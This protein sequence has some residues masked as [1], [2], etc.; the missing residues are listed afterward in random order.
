M[1][2]KFQ[3]LDSLLNEDTDRQLSTVDWDQLCGSIQKK[4]DAAEKEIPVTSIKQ[5]HLRWAVGI[6]AAAAVLLVVSLF[7]HDG[8]QSLPL[9]PGRRAVVQLSEQQSVLQTD[10]KKPAVSVS[11]TLP[12]TRTAV[13]FESPDIQVVQCNLTIIDRN[14]QAQKEEF[15]HPSWIIL[16]ASTPDALQS[17]TDKDQQDIACML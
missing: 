10:I 9:P 15:T 14:G 6:S 17:K 2:E 16:M 1:T 13:Q 3:N 7:I 8:K 11:I 12:D 5:R 4:L